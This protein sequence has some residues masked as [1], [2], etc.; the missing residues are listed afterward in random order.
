VIDLSAGERRRL[1]AHA[2]KLHPVVMIGDK[3]LTEAVLRA[4]DAGLKSH[5][6]VKVKVAGDDRAAREAVLAS[7][8]SA[9]DATPV[10]HIGKIL[11]LYRENPQLP[12]SPPPA[13]VRAKPA[14]AKSAR[15]KPARAE[16]ARI[17]PALAKPARA[18]PARTKPARAEP[19]RRA[20]PASQARPKARSRRPSK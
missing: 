3:G 1:R 11:V 14:R 20:G 15:A 12:A 13:P 17:K 18:K 5:E 7:I 10:Q 2:H 16:P 9:L 8:C 6:L 19:A 4:I